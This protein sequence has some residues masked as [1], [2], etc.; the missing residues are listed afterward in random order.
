[1]GHLC[2][3]PGRI[4]RTP[5]LLWICLTCV[6]SF[7]AWGQ[8]PDEIE[9]NLKP[10]YIDKDLFLRNFYGGDDLRYDATGKLTKGGDPE[11]WTV[12]MVHVKE[13]KVKPDHLEI[14]G[15]R[16]VLGYDGATKQFKKQIRRLCDPDC[17]VDKIRIQAELSTPVDEPQIRQALEHIFLGAN[18]SQVDLVPDYWRDFLNRVEVPKLAAADGLAF[19]V[20]NGVKPP[21]ALFQPDPEYSEVARAAK[22]Q[23][24]VTLFVVVGS[25]G[26]VQ[27][28][29]IHRPIG[30]GLDERAVATVKTWRFEPALRD[31]VPV[32]VQINVEVNF[33]LY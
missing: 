31:G 26:G 11:P 29:S 5:L 32:A 19:R 1:M 8:T 12:A 24:I 15:E 25:D 20:G 4:S 27:K 3:Q 17:H 23:G 13:L 33:R 9:K 7:A 22:F 16:V 21:K 18:E 30:M 28:I 2:R 6:F 10:A 14:R